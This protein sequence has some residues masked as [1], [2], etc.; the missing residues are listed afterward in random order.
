MAAV[1]ALVFVPALAA[2]ALM[3]GTTRGE[4]TLGSALAM[5]CFTMLAAGVFYGLF[6]MTRK[7]ESES[8]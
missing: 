7:W 2:L 4:L 5:T 3:F 6:R 8:P 1:M